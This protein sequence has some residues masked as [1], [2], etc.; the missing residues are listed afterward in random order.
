[1]LKRSDFSFL[2]TLAPLGSDKHYL[3]FSQKGQSLW[4]VGEKLERSPQGPSCAE[5]FSNLF[6]DIILLFSKQS[7]PA[8][9][10]F[11]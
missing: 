3:I 1:M 2:K 7:L 11:W 8:Y 4:L 6:Q 9:S 5:E 10:L